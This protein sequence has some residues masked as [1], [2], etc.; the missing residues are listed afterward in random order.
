MEN[1][2]EGVGGRGSGTILLKPNPQ[3]HNF[4]WHTHISQ[5]FELCNKKK[6]VLISLIQGTNIWNVFLL[7]Y[8]FFISITI[9]TF[10]S[11]PKSGSMELIV[12]KGHAL[13][14]LLTLPDN[15]C[16]NTNIWS[17]NG[18]K[19]R[20]IVEL[21]RQCLLSSICTG[22]VCSVHFHS[23]QIYCGICPL[24]QNWESQISAFL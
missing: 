7:I 15:T 14:I 11:S 18:S 12:P 5:Y 8:I 1:G 23:H 13:D 10:S 9:H 2:K 4:T 22:P 21:D 3:F 17:F 6:S 24:L 19:N 16:R 20:S